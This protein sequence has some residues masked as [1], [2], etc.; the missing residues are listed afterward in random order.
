MALPRHPLRALL[1]FAITLAGG[2]GLA[3]LEAYQH[4]SRNAS[5]HGH[6][7]HFETRGGAD[8]DDACRTWLT[9][10]PARHAAGT[11]AP[12]KGP[13]FVSR[14]LYDPGLASCPDR[15][16]LLPRSRAPP[17]TL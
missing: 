13:P 14:V 9:S 3:G 17:V 5:G 15:T 12:I 16:P 6:R 2:P 10:Q 11:P 4:A 8:H 1:L 7:T